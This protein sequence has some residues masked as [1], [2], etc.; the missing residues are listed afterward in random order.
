MSFLLNVT[1]ILDTLS[2]TLGAND[3]LRVDKVYLSRDSEHRTKLLG[4]RALELLYRLDVVGEEGFAHFDVYVEGVGIVYAIEYDLVVRRD[5]IARNGIC[6]YRGRR[7]ITAGL[8]LTPLLLS[9]TPCSSRS[10]SLSISTP[11]NA[12]FPF[13]KHK[14]VYLHN[15][16]RGYGIGIFWL[17]LSFPQAIMHT[18]IHNFDRLFRFRTTVTG[19]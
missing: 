10:S 1:E 8:T 2:L 7:L 12:R 15:L 17:F 5:L 16:F 13:R 3:G 14:F 6:K 4:D 18:V 9:S 19:I 11:S